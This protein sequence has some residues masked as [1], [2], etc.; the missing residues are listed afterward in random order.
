MDFELVLA[1]QAREWRMCADHGIEFFFHS[2]MHGSPAMG[3]LELSP[4]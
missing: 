3:F 4:A 1:P 2:A